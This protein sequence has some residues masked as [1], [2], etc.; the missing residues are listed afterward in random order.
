[1][2]AGVGIPNLSQLVAW[3]T[4][5]LTEAADHWEN[6]GGRSY[7]VAN[8]VWRD[9]LSI[10]WHGQRRGSKPSIIQAGAR[11]SRALAAWSNACRYSRP[12]PTRD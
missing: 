5:H 12:I 9:A 4:E 1:M 11:D 8:Q 6:M 7:G 2:S 10:D 3:P